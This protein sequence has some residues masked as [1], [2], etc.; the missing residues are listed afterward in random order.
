MIH[1]IP[2]V[3]LAIFIAFWSTLDIVYGVP[4]AAAPSALVV[5][6]LVVRALAG[7]AR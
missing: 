6:A 2:F 7:R 3:L 4:L 1:A 5:V